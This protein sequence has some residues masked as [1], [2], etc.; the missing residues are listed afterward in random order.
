M[1]T[2]DIRWPTSQSAYGSL[3]IAEIDWAFDVTIENLYRLTKLNAAKVYPFVF[4]R[5]LSFLKVKKASGL[6]LRR[7][8]RMQTQHANRK[9]CYLQPVVVVKQQWAGSELN[10]K[11]VL[12]NEGLNPLNSLVVSWTLSRRR[13]SE[14]SDDDYI[15]L[16][17]RRWWEQVNRVSFF[18][19]RRYSLYIQC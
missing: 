2:L 12:C 8:S 14:F 4:V 11:L 7:V 9:C 6:R 18:L 1:G 17:C 5:V 10:A 3:E 16:L 19:N 15:W 13:T